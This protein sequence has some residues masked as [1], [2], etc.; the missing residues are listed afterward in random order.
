MSIKARSSNK[1]AAAVAGGTDK[2][3]LHAYVE[4]HG[5]PHKEIFS[6]EHQAYAGL[7][8]HKAVKHAAVQHHSQP[9]YGRCIT[10]NLHL[11]CSVMLASYPGTS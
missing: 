4:G 8:N 9:W 2:Q 3:T 7:L 6:D 11:I 10:V 1:V 5:I